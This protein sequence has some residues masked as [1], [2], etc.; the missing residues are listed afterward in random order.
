MSVI[1]SNYPLE[2]RTLCISFL[3]VQDAACYASTSKNALMELEGRDDLSYRLNP[4]AI[5]A[6][7][8]KNIFVIHNDWANVAVGFSNPK[9]SVSHA[10]KI[11]SSAVLQVPQI[12]WSID[13]NKSVD[14]GIIDITDQLAPKVTWH[15]RGRYED[16]LGERVYTIAVDPKSKRTLAENGFRLTHSYERMY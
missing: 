13:C 9:L 5:P 6:S 12:A 2:V 8:L 15:F 3:D 10:M 1:F 7:L 14:E 11:L 4:H 16:G